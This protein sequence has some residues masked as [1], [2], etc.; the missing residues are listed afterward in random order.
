MIKKISLGFLTALLLAFMMGAQALAAQGEVQ[1]SDPQTSV[2]EEFEITAK[3]TC[4]GVLIGDG[5]LTL[6]YDP[7]Y[8]EFVEGTGSKD[9]SE[10]SVT[11]FNAGTGT[12][13]ELDYTIKFKALKEGETVV[14]VVDSEAY[15]WNNATLHLTLGTSTVTIG[16]GDG[17]SGAA[18]AK[19]DGP[20]VTIDGKKYNIVNDIPPMAIPTGFSVTGT[21]FSGEDVNVLQQDVSGQQA[22]YLT[23]GTD[24]QLF[25]YFGE[26]GQFVPM[27]LIDISE[28]AYIILLPD[29]GKAEVPK[30]F[31][32]ATLTYNDHE[33]P[34]W[35]NPEFPDYYLIYAL[36]SSGEKTMYL[37]DKKDETY[38]RYNPDLLSQKPVAKKASKR[39]G[40]VGTLLDF[41]GNHLKPFLI[42]IGAL[43]LLLLIWA[44]VLKRKVH[45]REVEIDDLYDELDGK[46]ARKVG[47][48]RASVTDDFSGVLPFDDDLYGDD[49][50][51]AYNNTFEF[52]DDDDFLRDYTNTLPV[53]LTDTLAKHKPLEANRTPARKGKK[54]QVKPLSN[55]RFHVD[56]DDTFKLDFI[57]FDE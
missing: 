38:Q 28:N 18:V 13:T 44:L 20:E 57:D 21:N 52:D 45:N 53:K 31:K 32:E 56:E 16:E 54:P 40:F 14:E 37:Y 11:I 48:P 19:G 55:P 2:G 12:E 47:G 39:S 23:D 9:E 1:F 10:G 4:G 8:L 50:F 26:D 3:M 7:E 46:K 41:I 51:E 35:Q 17:T 34:V 33:F 36:N 6:N 49:A 24:A 15:L 5:E 30:G 43:L 25:L 42:A 22:F 27:E 29:D